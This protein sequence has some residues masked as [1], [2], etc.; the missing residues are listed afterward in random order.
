MKMFD[1]NPKGRRKRGR[2]HKRWKDKF[3]WLGDRN[4]S[5]GLSL[6]PYDD[7]DD[8]LVLYGHFEK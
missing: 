2:P 5:K 6:V 3:T 1:C 8:E 4:R 7:D